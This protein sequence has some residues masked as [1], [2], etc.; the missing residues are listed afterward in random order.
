MIEN[1]IAFVEGFGPSYT[2]NLSYNKKKEIEQ[3]GNLYL[4][5][6]SLAGEVAAVGMLVSHIAENIINNNFAKGT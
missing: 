3:G 2:F 4:A 6:P 1:T 5:S